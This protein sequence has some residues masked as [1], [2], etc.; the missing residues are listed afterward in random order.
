MKKIAEKIAKHSK[1][2]LLIA[3][4]LL[5]PSVI[6]YINTD[7]NYDIL[8]YLPEDVSTMK[9]E[10]IMKEDF[11]CGSLAMLEIENMPDKDVAKI[12]EKVEKVKG[13]EEVIWKDSFIDLAF[14]NEMI[15]KD[16]RDMLYSGDATM[17]IVKLKEGTA[18]ELT[19]NA[20]DTIRKIA[21]KQA[22]LSGMSGIIKDTKDLSDEE[23]PYYVVVAGILTMIVLFLTMEYTAIPFIFL[24]NIAIAIIYNFGTNIIFGEISYITKAL[25]AILQLGVTMDYSIFLLHRYD[26]ELLNTDDRME[27]MAN[28]ITNTFTSI[29]GSSLTTVAGFIA[30]CA[31]DLAL[32][33]DIGIVMAKGVVLGVLTTVTVLPALILTFDKVIHNHKHR[34]ILTEFNK[35]S[36]FVI[37]NYKKLT[38][39]FL[40]LLV[41]AIYGNN[42]A[43]VYYNLDETLP[44]NLPSIVSTNKMKKDFDM[45]S[46]DMIF[47]KDSIDS[48]KIDK[49]V[50]EI[51]KVDGV[52]SVVALEKVVGSGFVQ[53]IIPDSLLSEVKSGGYEQIMIN[54]KY[55]A[56]T[57]ECG[58][59]LRELDKIVKKYDPKGLVGGEA[60][61]T[62]DLIR[63]ADTDFKKV[64][65]VSILA[66]FAI[67][68]F[69]FKSASIPVLLVAA[70]EGAIFANLGI[71][72]YTGTVLPFIASIVL[73]TIQLG[74]TVDY[75]ILLTS[76]FKE[77]LANGYDKYEAM[78]I[79]IQKCGRSIV[80][81][82]FS[83]FSSTIGVGLISKLEMISS[84][85]SLMARGAII[86][87]FVIL[88]MLPG[89][90]LL[91]EKLIE[92]TSKD[93][94]PKN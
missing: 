20:V 27:A 2:I 25:C 43:K 85:C 15:P 94:I 71:P 6:G 65:A 21:G 42:N 14:P 52:N 22:F 83:F 92:K 36:D 32:G 72:Y 24:V 8:S 81:S 77:E 17:M 35:T 41:P 67:I 78:K 9:A 53:D 16:M 40:I 10:K 57:K 12:K 74:A 26:E 84:L 3:F 45:N 28:A 23:M 86:S 47:V 11:N 19:M 79:A 50:S 58:V 39:L 51:E 56:A 63:I 73:G 70:I 66:I 89:L 91:S 54:S 13:V 18:D 33:K 34:T 88:F 82:G 93:F 80:T 37:R 75:A 59:Q 69:V 5:I 46:T 55:R 62:E 44:D 90:L 76:R 64:S 4:L 29:S 7:I 87:M 1:I 30:L 49:M 61:L 38:V 31:M 68:A 60:P 48:Y